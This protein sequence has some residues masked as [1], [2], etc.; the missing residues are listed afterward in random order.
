MKK[1]ASLLR[2]S[3]AAPAEPPRANANPDRHDAAASGAHDEATPEA[4]ATRDE[5]RRMS[6][7]EA[8]AL[9]LETPQ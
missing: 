3:Q 8:I 4:E 2:Q 6:R 1:F 7:K 9:A 5:G